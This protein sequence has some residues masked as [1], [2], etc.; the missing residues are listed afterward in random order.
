MIFLI[1]S[2][3]GTRITRVAIQ[4]SLGIGE[5]WMSDALVGSRIAR[6]YSSGGNSDLEI[7]TEL[8]AVRPT[9]L[10]RAALLRF[11]ENWEQAH[12]DGNSQISDEQ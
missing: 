7:S 6:K 8:T 1:R 12:P 10:G 5:S 4:A 11:L 3:Q 9:P 2:H